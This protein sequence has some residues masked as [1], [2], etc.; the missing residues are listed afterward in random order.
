MKQ[1]FA[2][3]AVFFTAVLAGCA[4]SV[5]S[6]SSARGDESVRFGVVTDVGIVR[7]DGD[8]QLGFSAAHGVAPVRLASNAFENRE[9]DRRAGQQFVVHLD[10]GQSITVT[11]PAGAGVYAGD[12]VRVEGNGQKARVTRS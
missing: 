5:G 8:H 10:D 7:I 11:Q 3:T 12:H 9:L 2:A 6:A 4:S 1:A